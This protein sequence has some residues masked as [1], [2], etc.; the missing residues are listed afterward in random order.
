MIRLPSYKTRLDQLLTDPVKLSSVI[1]WK[2]VG[3][4]IPWV[5]RAIPVQIQVLQNYRLPF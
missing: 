5:Q 3:W 2:D 4:I 1:P